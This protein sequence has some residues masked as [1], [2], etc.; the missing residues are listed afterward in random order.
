MSFHAP[1]RQKTQANDWCKYRN[2]IPWHHLSL[3][4]NEQSLFFLMYSEKFVFHK[5]APIYYKQYAWELKPYVDLCRPYVK[6]LHISEDSVRQCIFHLP[7]IPSFVPPANREVPLVISPA[8][9]TICRYDSFPS[10]THLSFQ[11]C[12]SSEIV[13]MSNLPR[14]LIRLEYEACPLFVVTRPEQWPPFLKVLKLHGYSQ[15]SISVY[16]TSLTSLKIPTENKVHLLP[17]SLQSLHFTNFQKESLDLSIFPTSLFKLKIRTPRMYVHACGHLPNLLH[18]TLCAIIDETSRIPDSVH[19]LALENASP[20]VQWPKNLTD[21]NLSMFPMDNNLT[22]PE[23][24]QSLRLFSNQSPFIIPSKLKK[25]IMPFY[26]EERLNEL[27]LPSTLQTL[28]INSLK[29]LIL[30]MV[31]GKMCAFLTD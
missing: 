31:D 9:E 18:F 28:V 3:F 29:K 8:I 2:H 19:T 16:P 30:E 6:T 23:T 21:L 13:D 1:K 22:F 14:S 10:L 15:T 17:S 20:R 25:L 11:C 4:C 27:I 26:P 12:H 5:C 7:S 24:L